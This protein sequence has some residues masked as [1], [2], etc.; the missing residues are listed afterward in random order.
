M[1]I[2]TGIALPSEAAAPLQ[3]V[4]R[5]MRPD[6]P[7]LRWTPEEKLHVPTKFIGEWPEERLQELERAL[8]AISASPLDIRIHGLG[9]MTTALYAGVEVTAPLNAL[10]ASM[11][12]ALEPLG[13]APEQ[14]AYRPHVTLAQ[15]RQRREHKPLP[16]QY[17]DAEFASFRAT[18]FH[19]YLSASGQY[20]KLKEFSLSAA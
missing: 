9:W 20:T 11:E 17:L 16:P 15:T 10:A 1:R 14:R 2:F 12:T 19:V 3:E 13:V 7:Q 8:A 18:S 6:H 5:A 4:M